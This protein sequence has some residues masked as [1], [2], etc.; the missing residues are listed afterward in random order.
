[1]REWCGKTIARNAMHKVWHHI[2]QKYSGKEARYVVIPVHGVFLLSSMFAFCQS[3]HDLAR[4]KQCFLLFWVEFCDDL[5]QPCSL[6]ILGAFPH[7]FTF[8]GE[9]DVHLPAV[10]RMR[11]AL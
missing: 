9:R 11:L 10:G 8:R 4:G 3:R 2:C 1:M 6:R 7:G 5:R